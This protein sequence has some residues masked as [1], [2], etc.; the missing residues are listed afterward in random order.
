MKF[1]NI[2]FLLGSIIKIHDSIHFLPAC[3]N[4]LPSQVTFYPTVKC[5]MCTYCEKRSVT[6]SWVTV[7][8]VMFPTHR[9]RPWLLA[10]RTKERRIS[11]NH[12]QLTLD[13]FT[14]K[15]TWKFAIVSLYVHLYRTITIDFVTAIWLSVV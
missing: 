10:L 5:S 9:A 15:F 11:S 1:S 13:T 8:E 4:L 7:L 2:A 14:E 12:H 3:I 6:I